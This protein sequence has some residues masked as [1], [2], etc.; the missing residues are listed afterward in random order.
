MANVSNLMEI[1]LDRIRVSELNTRKDLQAGNEDADIE[2]LANSIRARGLINPVTVVPR[3]DGGYDLIAGQRRFL[4]CKLLQMPTISAIVREN[5]NDNEAM[6]ISLVE[7]VQ[8]ADMNPIDKAR[9]Y[10]S[11][12]DEL[13]HVKGVAKETGVGAQTIRRYLSLLKLAPSLQDKV[14]TFD[15]PAG[16]GTLSKVAESY[17]AEEQEHVLDRI[18]GFNQRIQG[19]MLKRAEGDLDELEDLRGQ[20]IEGAFETRLCNDGLCF[21]LPDTW[22]SELKMLLERSEVHDMASLSKALRFP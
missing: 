8:R 1:D 3:S 17:P 12:L 13:E 18:G 7:N 15:G 21:E 20:A 10:Q 11:L 19:E 22:K 2:D 4:A 5:L 6:V 16:I 9:A 14:S